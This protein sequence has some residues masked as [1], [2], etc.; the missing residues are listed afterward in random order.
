M[1]KICWKGRLRLFDQREVEGKKG[2]EKRAG[3]GGRKG[4]KSR[5]RR[6]RRRVG[7]GRGLEVLA[8]EPR[9]PRKKD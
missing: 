4:R 1:V 7:R 2:G 8:K 6:Q 3:G 9:G 5:R